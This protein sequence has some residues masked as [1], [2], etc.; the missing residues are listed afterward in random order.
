MYLILS[1]DQF[2]SEQLSYV[3]NQD[4]KIFYTDKK[5]KYFSSINFKIVNKELIASID[6]VNIKFDIPI[7]FKKIQ[8]I[9]FQELNKIE[10]KFHDLSYNP[11]SQIV[12][13]KNK[14]IKLKSF[15]NIILRDLLLNYEE[16][17][18]KENIYANLWPN[19]KSI[20]INKL[21]THLTN[22]KNY[23]KHEIDFDLEFTSISGKIK[24]TL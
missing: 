20:L 2:L 7:S 5:N 8:Y 23:L 10:Y 11:I 18:L 14:F 19:D 21:D 22:L 15:H 6:K 13:F 1:Q 16:G 4:F 3:F 24:L 12:S 17:I 9:L